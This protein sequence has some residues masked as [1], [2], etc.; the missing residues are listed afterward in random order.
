MRVF[1]SR[2]GVMGIPWPITARLKSLTCTI[3]TP[4][5]I[6]AWHLVI[7]C[8]TIVISLEVLYW[9]FTAFSNKVFND[10]F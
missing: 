4:R 3:R 5:K 10:Q 7:R 8:E 9:V 6:N 2:I 1:D